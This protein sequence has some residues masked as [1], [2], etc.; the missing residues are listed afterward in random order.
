MKTHSSAAVVQMNLLCQLSLVLVVVPPVVGDRSEFPTTI[1]LVVN[2]VRHV[3]EVL[4]V[5]PGGQ[6][7]EVK[8][9]VRELDYFKSIL[10]LNMF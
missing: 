9:H 10:H 3:L 4:H 2:I 8:H 6:Q 1:V 7:E 5:C